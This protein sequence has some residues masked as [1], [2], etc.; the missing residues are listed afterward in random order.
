MNKNTKYLEWLQ[1][2]NLAP[3]TIRSYLATLAKFKQP[4]TTSGLKAHFLANL[5]T[6]PTP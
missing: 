1:D 5:P 6:K 3:H 4:F 2:K